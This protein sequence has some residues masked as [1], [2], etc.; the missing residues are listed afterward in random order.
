MAK[1]NR[2]KNTT[3][4]EGERTKRQ[5]GGEREVERER[6]TERGGSLFHYCVSANHR[7]RGDDDVC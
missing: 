4:E 7:K 3:E 5:R 1:S 2:K 6:E